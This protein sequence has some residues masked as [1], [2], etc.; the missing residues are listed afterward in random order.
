MVGRNPSAA[1]SSTRGVMASGHPS[2]N[3]Y[4]DTID[5][6]TTATT[7]NASDFGNLLSATNAMCNANNSP[8]REFFLVE[9]NHPHHIIKM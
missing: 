2:P 3:S 6:I 4:T 9:I 7:G 5:F 8:T 1:S